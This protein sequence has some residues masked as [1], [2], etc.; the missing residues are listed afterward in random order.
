MNKLHP[1]GPSTCFPAAAAMAVE[2]TGLTSGD[3]ANGD[4]NCANGEFV[5][6]ETAAA[7]CEDNED[8]PST[9]CAVAVPGPIC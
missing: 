4:V 1:S 7:N 3:A 8:N 9:F 5:A 2:T 6:G